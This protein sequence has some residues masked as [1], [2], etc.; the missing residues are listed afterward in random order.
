MLDKL[1]LLM[2]LNTLWRLWSQAAQEGQM[3]N[4]LAGVWHVV[5]LAAP[6][7]LGYF[8]PL[9]LH[10]SDPRIAALGAVLGALLPWLTKAPASVQ[11][12][13]SGGK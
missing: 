5:A 12:L 1:R 3:S 9:L 7:A 10:S 8:A 6:A 13:V 11:T 2:K 4:V